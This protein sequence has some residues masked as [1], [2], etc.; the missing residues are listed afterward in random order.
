MGSNV[1]EAEKILETCKERQITAALN[2]QLRFSPMM[3]C[4][5]DAIDKN[6]LGKI[7]DIDFHYSYYLPLRYLVKIKNPF[8]HGTLLIKRNIIDE[9]GL[10][11]EKFYYNLLYLFE[12]KLQN[13]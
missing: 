7:V 3:L 4:L 11:N 12:N 9:A 13:N 1:Q 8:I 2:F 5:K 10:Y 6:L